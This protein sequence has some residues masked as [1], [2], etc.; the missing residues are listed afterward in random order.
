MSNKELLPCP[1]CRGEAKVMGSDSDPFFMVVCLKCG[2]K[3]KW[4]H[5]LRDEAT[6]HWNERNYPEKQDS[7]NSSEKPNSSKEMPSVPEWQEN[8]AVAWLIVE[9]NEYNYVKF[10]FKKQPKILFRSIQN[11][12]K[13]YF[14]FEDVGKFKTLEEAK[15]KANVCIRELGEKLVYFADKIRTTE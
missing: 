5:D 10:E 9:L 11:K 12:T 15:Q 13:D 6:I 14:Y 3:A 1:F 8:K 4:Y 7:S 2:L